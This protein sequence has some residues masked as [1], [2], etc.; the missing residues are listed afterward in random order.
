MKH[1]T[2]YDPDTGIRTNVTFGAN[3]K[4]WHWIEQTRGDKPR[5]QFIRDILIKTMENEGKK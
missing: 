1:W 3:P 2:E 5:S 4:L